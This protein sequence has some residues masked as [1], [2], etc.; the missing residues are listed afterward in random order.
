MV[1]VGACEAEGPFPFHAEKAPLPEFT[2]ALR[3]CRIT[4]DPEDDNIAGTSTAPAAAPWTCICSGC[5]ARS[6]GVCLL[7]L[8]FTC[9]G[10]SDRWERG[11]V[12]GATAC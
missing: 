4:E 7:A 9:D 2:P 11:P 5:H 8:P 10:P 3:T 1:E 12:S 6:I